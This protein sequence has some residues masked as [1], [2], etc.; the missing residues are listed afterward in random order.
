MHSKYLLAL[1]MLSGLALSGPASAEIKWQTDSSAG[2]SGSSFG[3]SCNYSAGGVTA[4]A[5]AW[6]NTSGSSNTQLNTAYL[7]VYAGGGLGVKNQDACTAP[8]TGDANENISPE[9]AMDNNQRIDSILFTFSSK[10]ILGKVEIGYL[11]GDSD[12]SVLA[13]IGVGAPVM[14]GKTYADFQAS[15]DWAKVG[16]YANLATNTPK[17]VN[18]GNTA[19][20]YWLI[21]A[22]NSAFG[23]GTG[24]D[25][26]NDHVKLLALYG[27][28]PTPPSQV[29]LPSSLLLIG[30]GLLGFVR[31]RKP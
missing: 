4:N 23:S 21:S 7:G 13:Y 24:L 17:I 16:N 28:K 5:T 22:Y 15:S 2:C 3:N 30:A 14:I 12:I 10:V 26:G 6:S 29:P 11:S 18:A 25:T 31:L 19:S 1:A 20:S 8:C 27:D 9:H